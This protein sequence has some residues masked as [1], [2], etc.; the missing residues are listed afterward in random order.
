M[1][2]EANTAVQVVLNEEQSV[3]DVVIASCYEQVAQ[4]G[5]YSRVASDRASTI[6][7]IRVCPMHP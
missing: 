6:S 3:T 5:D 7:R 2:Q 1:T 4:V